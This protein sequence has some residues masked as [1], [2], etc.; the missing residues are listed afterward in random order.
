M[1][2]STSPFSGIFW[3]SGVLITLASA[4]LLYPSDMVSPDAI[5]CLSSIATHIP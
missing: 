1:N 5:T 3:K 2:T 4:T